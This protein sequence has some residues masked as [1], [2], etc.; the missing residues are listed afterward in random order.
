MWQLFHYRIYILLMMVNFI[1]STTISH[2]DV[3]LSQRL[4]MMKDVCLEGVPVDH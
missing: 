1:L 3:S 4:L 2:I